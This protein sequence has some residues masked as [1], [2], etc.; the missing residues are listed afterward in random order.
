[1]LLSQR[2]LFLSVPEDEKGDRLDQRQRADRDAARQRQM[3]GDD[4]AVGM[5]DD[6][7]ARWLVPQERLD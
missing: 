6:M 5:P 1:M 4:P 2:R 3:Q 7:H